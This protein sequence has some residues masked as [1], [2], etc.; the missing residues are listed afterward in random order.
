MRNTKAGPIIILTVLTSMRI[1]L[2]PVSKLYVKLSQ[3]R[4]TFSLQ[5]ITLTIFEIMQKNSIHHLMKS[6][7]QQIKVKC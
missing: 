7:M 1:V 2:R 3:I 4:E 5:Y 6:K